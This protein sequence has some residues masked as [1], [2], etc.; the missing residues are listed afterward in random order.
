ML[1][2]IKKYLIIILLINASVN[3]F[4]QEKGLIL[5]K[6]YSSKDYN[7]GTQNWTIAQDK[8]GIMYFG[9]YAGVLKYN[10]VNWQQINVSNNLSVRCLP[11]DKNNILF[12]GAHNEVGYLSPWYRTI[13]AYI[14]YSIFVIMLIALIVKLYT[15]KLIRERNKLEKQKLEITDQR[16]KLAVIN[17]TKNKFFR[18]IAHDLRGPISTL[19]SSTSLIF[20]NFDIYKKDDTKKFIGELSRLSQTTYDLLENLLDWSS[21]QTGDISF[22][23]QPINILLIA[24]ETIELIKQNI[25]HKNISLKLEIDINTTALADEN[26]IKTVFRNLL[27]NAVKFTPENGKIEILASVKNKFIYCIVKDSGVGIKEEDLEKIFEID[28]NFTSLRLDNEKGSGLGLILC[29]EFIEKNGGKIKIDS[30]INQGTTIEFTLKNYI[31]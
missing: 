17:A 30:T 9:N 23:P 19:A 8:K 27:S 20:N 11:F 18:I 15:I 4:A 21:T 5:S 13:G 10:S 6:F 22:A 25:S 24:K 7:A 26:M 3:I 16:D 1:K 2:N 12:V 29:K 28:Q 14:G 31:V